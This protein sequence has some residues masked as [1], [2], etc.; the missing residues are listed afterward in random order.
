[1]RPASKVPNALRK[2]SESMT[3]LRGYCDHVGQTITAEPAPYRERNHLKPEV[4]E[5]TLCSVKIATRASPCHLDSTTQGDGENCAIC[6]A[7]S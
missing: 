1:M 4:S 6:V 5:K 2:A 7:Y 3:S